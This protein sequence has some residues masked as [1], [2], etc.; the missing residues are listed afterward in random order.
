MRKQGISTN[1]L[2]CI[3]LRRCGRLAANLASVSKHKPYK[4]QQTENTQQ[5]Q[6]NQ[7]I[8]EITEKQG[9]LKIFC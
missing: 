9:K 7:R 2:Y 3:R 6:E 5:T 1:D 4:R 8:R